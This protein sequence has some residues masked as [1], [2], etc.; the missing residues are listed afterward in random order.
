[1]SRIEKHILTAEEAWLD[2]ASSF[3]EELFKDVFLPSHDHTHH[4]RTWQAA[5]LILREIAVFNVSIS[6]EFVEA[7]LLASLFHDTGI[8]ETRGILHGQIGKHFYHRFI[9]EN[10]LEEPAWHAQ[11]SYAIEMHDQ[12]TENLFVPFHWNQAPDLLTVVSIADDMDALG[13]IGI[14]R[15][16]E[17]YLHRGTALKSLGITVLE[18]VSIRF[19][20]L[21]KASTLVP[22]LV[23]KSKIKYQEILNFFDN[24]NQQLLAE[25]DPNL[26][27]SGHIG[28]VNYIRDF[29][30]IGE[31]H[32]LDFKRSLEN[33]QTGK[34][35]LDYFAKLEKELRLA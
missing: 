23:N 14:Y 1:M 29:S 2:K 12:K 20:H 28:I 8:S 30:V 24:Y 7:V 34:Y 11:I 19:N 25:E 22:S 3:V 16:A 26:V 27:F 5:K 4:L 33:F 10:G 9:A 6:K 35:V 15:Y 21:S 32:P 31:I 18:N 13:I 17:I